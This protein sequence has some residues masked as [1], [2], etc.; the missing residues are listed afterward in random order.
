MEMRITWGEAPWG[1][2]APIS[3]AVE[4]GKIE[5]R[6]GGAWFVGRILEGMEKGKTSYCCVL[7]ENI[8]SI[9]M[10]EA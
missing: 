7:V 8:L 2:K 10:V 3:R 1:E 4:G 9:E 5:F 6:E